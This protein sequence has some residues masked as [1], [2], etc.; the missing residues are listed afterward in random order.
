MADQ[1][2]DPYGHFNFLVEIDG[3]TRA[4]FTECTGLSTDTDPI[5]YREGAD[6]IMSVRKLSGLRKYGNISLKRGLTKDRDLWNWRKQV[7]DVLVVR[8]SVAIILLDEARSEVMRWNFRE[9][10]P[11]KWEGPGFN[12]KTSESA[13]ETLDLVHEGFA[14]E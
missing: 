1:R 2:H 12:A 3:I 11:T 5:D 4:G 7:I 10:W 6:A 13:I 14:P 8:K 9:A